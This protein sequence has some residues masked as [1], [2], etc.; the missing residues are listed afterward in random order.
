MTTSKAPIPPN[1]GRKS[2]YVARNRKALINSTQRVL[3]DV[4]PSAT[5]EQISEAATMSVSTIYKHFTDKDALITAAIVEAM[6]EW[7]EW[8][9]GILENVS[10]PF[11]A[12]V[13]PM[14]L[15]LRSHE[16]HP[17]FARMAAQNTDYVL[18]AM[19]GITST[20]TSHVA[21]LINERILLI[22]K[23][24]IRIRNVA[25]CLF[26]AL[27]HQVTNPTATKSDGDNAVEIAI[28]ML[29]I[30]PAKAKE[31]AHGKIPQYVSSK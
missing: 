21:Q 10:D 5:I 7:E 4:G 2:A 30:T 24:E 17:L 6:R 16:T 14:R 20:L 13:I 28:G 25:A 8:S 1:T 11:E 26:A 19:A 9:D 22:D 31:L 3:A 23:P 12:L 18:A 15:F 29:G 27:S